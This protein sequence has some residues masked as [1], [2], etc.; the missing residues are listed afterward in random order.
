MISSDEL[1]KEV[2]KRGRVFVMSTLG[3]FVEVQKA[4]L[5]SDLADAPEDGTLA[6]D[7]IAERDHQDNLWIHDG[8]IIL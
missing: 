3:M 1:R 7:V 8:E 4:G 2:R 5:L 6:Y